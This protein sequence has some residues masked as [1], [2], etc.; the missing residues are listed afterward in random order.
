LGAARNIAAEPIIRREVP[1]RRATCTPHSVP[2]WGTFLLLLAVCLSGAGWG[3]WRL[4][5]SQIRQPQRADEREAMQPALPGVLQGQAGRASKLPSG[6]QSGVEAG[7][8]VPAG[9]R[10]ASG[11]LAQ[12]AVGL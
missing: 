4:Y 7:S 9:I 3:G 11:G 5:D 12:A 6:A 8:T 1:R 10:R 2:I